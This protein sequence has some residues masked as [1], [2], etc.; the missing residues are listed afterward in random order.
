MIEIMRTNDMVLISAVEAALVEAGTP[1]F[2]ADAHMS[3]LEGSIGLFQRRI[4]VPD[5]EA[6]E[7]RRILEAAGFG[8]DLRRE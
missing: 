8:A 4:L 7:A 3:V 1:Y 6:S 2:I 5:D